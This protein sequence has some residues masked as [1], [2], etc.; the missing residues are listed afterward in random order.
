MNKKLLLAII[1]MVSGIILT[2]AQCTIDSSC[3]KL[4]CPDTI[5]NLPDAN[6]TVLYN[7]SL[8]VKVPVDTTIS[9]FPI[10]VDS[11][12]YTSVTGLPSGFTMTPNKSAWDG[13]TYGCIQITGTPADSMQGKTYKLVI[14]VTAHG[15]YTTIPFSS[16][17]V[18]NGYK[19]FVNDTT[20]G[21]NEINE[22]N[23]VSFI[24]YS[25]D[26]KIHSTDVV[27]NA[28][29]IV[30]DITGRE[31]MHLNNMNGNDFII[32][33]GNLTKGIYIISLL[34]N[35]KVI[36]RGKVIIG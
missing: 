28:T 11:L 8:T 22:Q 10:T 19:I 13:G 31:L 3:N 34:N 23:N 35:Q 32:N 25:D 15:M 33:K 2:N 14:T 4:V 16:P 20:L 24:Y 36:A 1:F 6:V 12:N 21:I 29:I 18:V 7:T 5:T 26:I 17:E 27:N 9:G 30:N